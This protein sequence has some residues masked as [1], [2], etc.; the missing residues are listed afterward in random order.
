[1]STTPR[2]PYDATVQTANLSVVP[3]EL[4]KL[5]YKN[6]VLNL[7]NENDPF[8]QYGL[9]GP[10]NPENPPC[11]IT[12]NSLQGG[13]EKVRLSF[14]MPYTTMPYVMT[15]NLD[16][17]AGK[18][19]WKHLDMTIGAWRA[20]FEIDKKEQQLP[21]WELEMQTVRSIGPYH[22]YVKAYIILNALLGKDVKEPSTIYDAG[23]AASVSNLHT[24][25]PCTT[26]VVAGDHFDVA[27]LDPD[28]YFVSDLVARAD[29]ALYTGY[30]R[31]G[32]TTHIAAKP[33][34][35][36]LVI[37]MHKFSAYQLEK[38]DPDFA[39]AFKY[40]DAPGPQNRN[41]GGYGSTFM[42]KGKRYIILDGLLGNALLFSA[43]DTIVDED[44]TNKTAA[45]NGATVIAMAGR[46]LGYITGKWDELLDVTKKDG[47]WFTD[48]DT[49]QFMA[50]TAMQVYESGSS[51]DRDLGRCLIHHTCEHP[52][53]Y[54]NVA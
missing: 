22:K 12:D 21:P 53:K 34:G 29:S 33:P 46:A 14:Q 8:T 15:K 7:M 50:C 48:F 4:R 40:A 28:D 37:L 16:S 11:I 51:E 26:Q 2:I 45:Q 39:Q 35:A 54:T 20:K 49:A 18:F 52:N 44:G 5:V 17:W 43:G 38:N 10:D 13:G 9:M 32:S 3:S 36:D 27:Q 42:L 6:T 1:M 23:Y 24:G 41:W 19:V 47:N 30:R 31:Q 25:S